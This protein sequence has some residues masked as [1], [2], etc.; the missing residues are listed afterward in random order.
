MHSESEIHGRLKEIWQIFTAAG[1]T[2]PLTIIENLAYLFLWEEL[3]AKR[4]HIFKAKSRFELLELDGDQD[5]SNRILPGELLP[6]LCNKL[7]QL[8]QLPNLNQLLPQ[9][10]KSFEANILS[11]LGRAVHALLQDYPVAPKIFNEALPEFLERMEPG[12]RYFTPRHLTH[13]AA[14]LLDIHPGDTLADFA[15][16]SGGFLVAAAGKHPKM[17]GVELSPNWARLAFTN[18]LLHGIEN[19]DIRIGNSLKIIGKDIRIPAFDRILMNPPFGAKVDESLVQFAFDLKLSNRSETVLA[20]LA[21]EHLAENGQMVIFLPS[22]SLF[23][24]NWG[25]QV[26]REMLIEEGYLS[27]V[28]SFPNDAFQPYSHVSTHALLIEKQLKPTYQTWF[29]QARFDGFT[30]GRNRQPDPEHNDLP[31]IQAAIYNRDEH[32]DNQRK[33]DKQILLSGKAIKHDDQLLGY[34]IQSDDPQILRLTFLNQ[35]FPNKETCFLTKV[36]TPET[37]QCL[38]IDLHGSVH[39]EE[40]TDFP[41]IKNLPLLR[42]NI[43]LDFFEEWDFCIE[44]SPQGGTYYEG[45][46]KTNLSFL[47][48]L[49]LSH[50]TGILLYSDGIPLTPP[51]TLP[52]AFDKI[53]AGIYYWY[54]DTESPP[55]ILLTIPPKPKT[56]FLF[57]NREGK[58]T[59][60]VQTSDDSILK[61]TWDK[62]DILHFSVFQ[63]A[64]IPL[65]NNP[66]TGV[67]V[68][69]LGALIGLAISGGIIQKTPNLDLQ[70]STYFPRDGELGEALDSPAQI[71]A[72]IELSQIELSGQINKLLSLAELKPTAIEQLPPGIFPTYPMGR[73]QGI[74][75]NVWEVIQTRA[76]EI[77]KKTI[78]VPFQ[79]E[80]LRDETSLKQYS[81]DDLNRVLDLFERMGIVVRISIQ[82]APY[83]RLTSE[84]EVFTGDEQS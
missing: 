12:G 8:N 40:S 79:I 30:S 10:T 51:F 41:V 27:S 33:T 59:Y 55:G 4:L 47:E 70:P 75:K 19:P 57:T 22:G 36:D 35:L 50:K 83:Y 52:K 34:Q 5:D 2:D 73:I 74:Q 42:E 31:L 71:L 61:I 13:W 46:K 26:I 28:I 16:G 1:V 69:P 65:G 48:G 81:T 38:I 66:L 18:C 62:N 17:T 68:D 15:C 58:K 84:R 76:E 20:Y 32:D 9:L 11:D 77:A 49:D 56:L 24:N 29:F 80:E 63:A 67:V 23:A 45:A 21:I 54:E 78:P 44:L 82:G 60:L 6:V 64:T 37:K 43:K 25:E 14:S 7:P 3:N 72:N 39:G 53:E